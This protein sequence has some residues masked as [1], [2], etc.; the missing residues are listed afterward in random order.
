MGDDIKIGKIGE[1][2]RRQVGGGVGEAVG[3]AGEGDHGGG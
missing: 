2:F 3:Q 1:I